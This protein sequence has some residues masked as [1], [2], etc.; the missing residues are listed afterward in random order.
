[1]SVGS[2]SGIGFQHLPQR[3]SRLHRAVAGLLE[4]LQMLPDLPFVPGGEDLGQ[5]VTL[6]AVV[7]L[8]LQTTTI[9]ARRRGDG[10]RFQCIERRPHRHGPA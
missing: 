7:V 8:L 6:L 9:E 4:R 2:Q 10:R 3:C 1:M 5:V